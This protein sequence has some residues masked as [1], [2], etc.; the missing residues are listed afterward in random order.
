MLHSAVY[1]GRNRSIVRYRCLGSQNN[2]HTRTC[3]AFA[4]VRPDEAVAKVI[5]HAIEPSAIEAAITAAERAAHQPVER[6]EGL[7]LELEQARYQARLAARRYEAVDPDNR[8]VAAELEARWNA[9]LQQVEE[10]ERRLKDLDSTPRPTSTPDRDLLMSLAQDLPTVWSTSGDMR[11]KQR[12]TRILIEEIV[13]NVDTGSCSRTTGCFCR[14]N[15][16]SQAQR[17][18]SPMGNSMQGLVSRPQNSRSNWP[19]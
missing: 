15:R 19:L 2:E 5:L 17:V 12:I 3:L 13:A 14:A 1:G 4:G 11:L 7:C 18:P 16:P 10:L 6:R 8:L 9:A